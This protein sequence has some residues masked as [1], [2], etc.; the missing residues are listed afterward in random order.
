MEVFAAES[1]TYNGKEGR[2][3]VQ[4]CV[5]NVSGSVV[6]LRGAR[7]MHGDLVAKG[8]ACARLRLSGVC[9]HVYGPAELRSHA[10]VFSLRTLHRTLRT[11]AAPSMYL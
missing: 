3:I 2:L 5:F 4:R 8:C 1:L 11:A 9:N 6:L 10:R 7:E